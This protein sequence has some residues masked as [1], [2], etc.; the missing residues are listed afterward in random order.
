MTRNPTYPYIVINDLPKVDNLKRLFPG[1]YRAK[2]VLVSDARA[3][4]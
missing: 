4:N 1:L 3:S 2:P